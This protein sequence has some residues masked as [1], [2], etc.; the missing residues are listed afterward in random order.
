M[1]LRLFHPA[2]DPGIQYKTLDNQNSRTGFFA[3]HSL[4][5]MGWYTHNV[6]LRLLGHYRLF[7]LYK[8]RRSGSGGLSPVQGY[9]LQYRSSHWIKHYWYLLISRLPSIFAPDPV[10]E[11][12]WINKILIHER[13]HVLSDFL[14]NADDDFEKAFKNALEGIN[15][16]DFISTAA[17]KKETIIKEPPKDLT[18]KEKGVF[19]KKQVLILF[20]LLSLIGKKDR[21]DLH[22]TNNHANIA[23]FFHALTGKGCNTWMETLRDYPDNDLYAFNTPE[24][25]SHLI[26]ILTNIS[27]I[28]KSAGLRSLSTN[29]EKKRRALEDTKQQP[30]SGA[31]T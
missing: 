31:A 18:G 1:D 30:P 26:G 25:R 16:P 17:T 20:D 2:D 29:A 27:N 9:I 13:A 21:I 8:K 11:V 22:M 4:E 14:S 19:S 5:W 6:K 23:Q 7:Q 24:E 15:H 12:Y 28:A 3:C 10:I